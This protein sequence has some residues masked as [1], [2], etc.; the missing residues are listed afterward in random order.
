MRKASTRRQLRYWPLRLLAWGCTF[1]L[2][3]AL[4][5]TA[6]ESEL[7]TAALVA[8]LATFW[9]AAIRDHSGVHFLP[10]TAHM[11]CWARAVAGLVPAIG[12]VALVLLRVAALGGSPWR[13][14]RWTFDYGSPR[15]PSDRARRASALLSASLGPEAYVVR[16]PAGRRRALAHTLRP[17]AS[18]D[19]RWLI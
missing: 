1:G 18:P 19:R 9:S 10:S 2:Y 12:R 6:R 3:L 7:I 11:R 5:G 4:T 13:A 8:S 17:R 14:A 16:L 15:D